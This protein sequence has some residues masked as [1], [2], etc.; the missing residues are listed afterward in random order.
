MAQIPRDLRE[1]IELLNSHDVKYLIVGGYAV[2]FHGHPRTTGDID[3]FIEISEEN[4]SKLETVMSEFGFGGS[5]LTSQ[6]FL[7]PGTIF[8]WAI[9]RI[10]L[11]LS[12]PLVASRSLKR[13]SIE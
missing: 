8:N 7:D 11:I 4:A 12:H 13:G 5:G 3:F 2:A 6:D 1:F 10:A 9:R